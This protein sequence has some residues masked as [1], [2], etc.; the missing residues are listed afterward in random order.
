MIL[1]ICYKAEDNF[2]PGMVCYLPV[3]VDGWLPADGRF[4]GCD[5]YRELYRAIGD[6]YCPPVNRKKMPTTIWGRILRAF[7]AEYRDRFI[8]I[9][10]EE[11]RPGYFRLPLVN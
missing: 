6:T 1:S 8:E 9:P 10:N 3:V 2:I 7:G 11:Y 5:E 4:C